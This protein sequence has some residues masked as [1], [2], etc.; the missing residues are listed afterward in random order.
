MLERGHYATDDVRA[1]GLFLRGDIDLPGPHT[2]DI[3]Y[4]FASG[5]KAAGDGVRGGYDT[6]Y[7]P[8]STFGSL[9]QLKGINARGL[10]VGGNIVIA[11]PLTL[12]WRYLNTSLATRNDIW[13]ASVMPDISRPD[14]TSSFLG[15]ETD[16][17]LSYRVSRKLL[18]RTG[19]Y[20]F[21]PG[22][23]VADG[24]R[25]DPYELRMQIIGGT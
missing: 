22:G 18:V 11:R 13:H 17:T 10:N 2:L 12:A 5:D 24:P 25:H 3:R 6:F 8:A 1:W 7:A 14:A 9:G 20:R 21:F 15:Q 19:Y 23:Y 16:F 4:S